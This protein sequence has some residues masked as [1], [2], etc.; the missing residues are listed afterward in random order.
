M[1]RRKPPV[2]VRTTPA[3][4]ARCGAV[5]RDWNVRPADAPGTK[6]HAGQGFC[7]A[8]LRHHYQTELV[9]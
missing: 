7:A 5:L 4:C 9:S 8:C 1:T 3:N 6:K 2:R